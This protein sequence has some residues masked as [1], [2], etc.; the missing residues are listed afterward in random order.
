[1]TTDEK[2]KHFQ[3]ICMEDARDRSAKMLDSYMEALEQ[4]FAEHQADAKRRADNEVAVETEKLE[5][6]TNKRLSIAHLDLKR[7]ISHKQEELKDKLF[8]EVRDLLAN[9]M[10][11]QEYQKLLERQVKEAKEVS[12]GAPIDI[13][14]DPADADLAERLALHNRTAVRTGERSFMG[15]VLAV[16]P[17]KH[18]L[19]DNSFGTKLKEARREFKFEMGGK[20]SG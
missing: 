7:E 20:Q 5:R 4:T 14:L 19:I 12:Q 6:E 2:L 8:V 18:I 10:G 9:F 3:D 17:S 1:M 13:F 16:I 15:G 11:T